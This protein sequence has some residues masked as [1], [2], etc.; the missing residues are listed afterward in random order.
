MPR[1]CRAAQGRY[2]EAHANSWPRWHWTLLHRATNNGALALLQ[3]GHGSATGGDWPRAREL[4]EKACLLAPSVPE[5]WYHRGLAAS[6]LRRLSEARTCYE[7]AIDLCFNYAEAHNNLGHILEAEGNP[8]EAIRA[9]ERALAIRPGYADAH[10][11]LALTLQNTGRICAAKAQYES[12]LAYAI[13]HADAPTA[14]PQRIGWRMPSGN[15][16]Y[17]DPHRCAESVACTL[18]VSLNAAAV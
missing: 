4:Y 10:Y 2:A 9:Y 8:E 5:A 3:W 6:A 14:L 12:L 18:L 7:R 16:A 15:S 1:T 11:N 17:G 13:Q